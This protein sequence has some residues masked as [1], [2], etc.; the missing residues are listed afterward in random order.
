ML[1]DNRK[2]LYH[3]TPPWIRASDEIYFITINCCDRGKDHLANEQTSRFL[4]DTIAHY[5]DQRLWYP[6]LVLFMPDHLHGLFSFPENGK[7]MSELFS[8]WK[9][10]TAK[11]L[12]FKWQTAFFDHRIRSNESYDEKFDYIQNNPVRAGLVQNKDDWPYVQVDWF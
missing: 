11:H 1:P 2:W 12:N 5:C 9:S 4:L 8:Q 10:Y 3:S 7:P 6:H